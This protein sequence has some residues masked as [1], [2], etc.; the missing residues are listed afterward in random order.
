MS[1]QCGTWTWSGSG[2]QTNGQLEQAV[3][4]LWQGLGL[5]LFGI[6]A[7]A[8]QLVR[9]AGTALLSPGSLTLWRE[10]PK[11]IAKGGN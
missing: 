11:E 10:S 9:L 7:L 5:M 6:L 3:K 2:W 8:W 4:K 1:E